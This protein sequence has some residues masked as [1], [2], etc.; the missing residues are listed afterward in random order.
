MLGFMLV[1][2]RDVGC[3]DS[4]VILPIFKMEVWQL[5]ILYEGFRQV[6]KAHTGLRNRLRKVWNGVYSLLHVHIC[7]F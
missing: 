1:L 3:F 2:A 7:I 6:I 4:V 5:A